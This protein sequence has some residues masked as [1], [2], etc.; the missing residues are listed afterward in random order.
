MKANKAA[1]DMTQLQMNS[2]LTESLNLEYYESADFSEFE[3]Y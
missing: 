3:F 2:N 1:I